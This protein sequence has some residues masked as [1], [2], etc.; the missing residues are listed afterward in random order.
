MNKQN[1]KKIIKF[2]FFTALIVLICYFIFVVI[3]QWEYK[4]L[5]NTFNDGVN[6]G[7]NQ[8]IL[9]INREGEI[10]VIKNKTSGEFEFTPIGEVCN[11]SK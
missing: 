6:Y 9:Y 8:I 11:P 1:L 4:R 2:A 5:S 10:P 7:A 3:P